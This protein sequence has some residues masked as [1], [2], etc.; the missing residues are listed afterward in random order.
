MSQDSNDQSQGD[1][2]PNDVH[3]TLLSMAQTAAANGDHQMAAE[4]AAGGMDL[5]D[6]E[7]EMRQI[8]R[9]RARRF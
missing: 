4:M 3:A 6:F 5:I 2:T 7:L 8:E 9:E 1:T